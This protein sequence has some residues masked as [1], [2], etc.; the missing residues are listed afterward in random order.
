MIITKEEI[1]KELRKIKDKIEHDNYT[2]ENI[3]D[4]IFKIKNDI[5]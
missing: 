4:L 5:E 1:I 3:D 2:R